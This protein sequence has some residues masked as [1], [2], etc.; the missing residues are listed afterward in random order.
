MHVDLWCI[1]TIKLI[2]FSTLFM[3]VAINAYFWNRPNT[4]SGQYTRQLVYHLNRLVADLDITLVYPQ[5]G[6]QLE[7][8]QVPSG[9]R[10][11]A[12]PLRPGNL[13]KVRF[14]QL[15]F[16]RACRELGATLAHVP[17][18]AAPL[19][20][21]VPLV[22]TVHDL[23]TLLFPEYNRRAAVRLY[24]A[25]VSAGARGANH[26]ITDSFASKLDILSHLRIREE[27]VTA[28]YLGVNPQY[29]PTEGDL[30][31]MAVL[32][33]YDL[34]DFYILYLGGY[35]RHKNVLN[36]LHAYTYVAQALGEE[37]PLILAGKKP[38][39]V[40]PV[41]PDYDDYIRRSKLEK[42]VRWIGFVD[43]ED[44][45]I[46]YRN[47]ETFIFPSRYEGFGLPPLEAMACG[48]PVVASDGG[49]LLEVIGPAGFTLDPD[50]VRSMAGS[51]IATVMQPELAAELRQKGL[52]QAAKFT[53]E[54]TAVETLLIYDQ[55]SRQ[56][57]GGK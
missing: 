24:N 54:K 10:I 3:H 25:L 56:A 4:G 5:L 43:E 23:T 6:G 22:V 18:W 47:A 28:I 1:S 14:E 41:F 52:E 31:E 8:K 27:R 45:P 39:K 57:A 29:T 35:E 50:D 21:P 19:R 55:V 32:R 48:T 17:Y 20:S 37:Y 26:V 42:F 12:V 53:W 13:G 49:S 7:A 36:L 40:T 16:P 15:D 44:K 33:K 11:H 38:D 2:L 51:I 34:P 30:L 9:V 46:L